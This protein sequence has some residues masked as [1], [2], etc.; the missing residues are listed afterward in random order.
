MANANTFRNNSYNNSSSSLRSNGVIVN[1]NVDGSRPTEFIS[2][3]TIPNNNYS[4]NNGI[5]SSD[6]HHNNNGVI[7]N[8]GFEDSVPGFSNSNNPREITN[9]NGYKNAAYV[10]TE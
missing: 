7:I 8:Q 2:S 5:S 10:N 3:L 1:G 4:N 6:N 9:R